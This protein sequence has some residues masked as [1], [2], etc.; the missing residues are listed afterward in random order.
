MDVAKLAIAVGLAAF[1]G[2]LW[3]AFIRRVP[4]QTAVGTIISKGEVA[5]RT[6]VQQRV[7]QGGVPTTPNTIEL[8]P[9]N[10]FE[11]R[12]DGRSSPVHASFNTVLGREFEPGQRVRVNYTIRGIPLVWQR[13]TVTD[14]SPVDSR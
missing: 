5:D 13:V 14:M 3:F 12:L 4:E 6:F 11:I 10:T 9:A 2:I 7:G 1:A 8:A